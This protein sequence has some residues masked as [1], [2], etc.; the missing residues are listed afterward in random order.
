[1]QPVFL[2]GVLGRWSRC[3]VI[4]SLALNTNLT[5]GDLLKKLGNQVGVD[6]TRS[7]Y[8]SGR[9]NDGALDEREKYILKFQVLVTQ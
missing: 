4:Y 8:M 3:T 5:T 7:R 6:S 9:V 1:M 2:A